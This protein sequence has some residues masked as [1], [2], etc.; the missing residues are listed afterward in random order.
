MTN[1]ISKVAEN[2]QKLQQAISL[3]KFIMDIDDEEI[4]KSTIE[5]VIEVMEEISK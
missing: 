1:R 5:S 3:L 4:V 2:K